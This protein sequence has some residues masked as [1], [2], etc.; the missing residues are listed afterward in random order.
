LAQEVREW[1][2]ASK[3]KGEDDFVFVSELNGWQPMSDSTLR[4]DFYRVR[5]AAGI[6]AE[7]CVHH[8][9]DTYASMII[10]DGT[11]IT[12]VAALLGHTKEDGSPNPA[13]TLKHYAFMFDLMSG[14]ERVRD[15][16]EK[17]AAA[18]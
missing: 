16:L 2:A 5:D 13:T 10:F 1:R 7:M 9:R 4:A 11:P 12:Q 17:R 8:M 6:D 3:K 14:N 18:L 15:S